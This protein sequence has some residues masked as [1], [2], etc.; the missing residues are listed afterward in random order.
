M[1]FDQLLS[2]HTNDVDIMPVVQIR[3]LGLREKSLAPACPAQK[4][5]SWDSNPQSP[6]TVHGAVRVCA[7]TFHEQQPTLLRLIKGSN[8]TFFFCVLPMNK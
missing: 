2:N 5:Q 4:W 3:Q 1:K 8:F 6:G 7:Y